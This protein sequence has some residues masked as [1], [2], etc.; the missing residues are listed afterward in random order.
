MEE[1]EA[2]GLF[3]KCEDMSE[4]PYGF[5]SIRSVHDVY[6]ALDEDERALYKFRKLLKKDELPRK[7]DA[8]R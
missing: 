2:N 3:G 7:T 6:E 8:L 5:G 1:T 4:Y